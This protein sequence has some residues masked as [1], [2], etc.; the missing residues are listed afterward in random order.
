MIGSE[1]SDAR[2]I[3]ALCVL[4][5]PRVENSAM[6]RTAATNQTN[7][8]GGRK[9]EP[10]APP[11]MSAIPDRSMT[12]PSEPLIPLSTRIG[13]QDVNADPTAPEISARDRTR[14][15]SAYASPA[16]MKIATTGSVRNFVIPELQDNA[17]AI[18][19]PAMRR[20]LSR[21]CLVQ[22]LI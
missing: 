9:C 7:S 15:A 4:N 20:D 18:A 12:A 21:Y 6:C 1:I 17:S 13:P 22:D 14:L 5:G 16:P 11:S 3:A 10:N 19:P 8:S 2:V